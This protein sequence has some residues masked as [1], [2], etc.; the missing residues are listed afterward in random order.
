[1]P[2][3]SSNRRV[4]EAQVSGTRIVSG[5]LQVPVKETLLSGGQHA[6]SYLISLLFSFSRPLSLALLTAQSEHMCLE[7][8]TLLAVS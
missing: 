8:I 2:V 5:D 7:I 3:I 6:Y 1:M 4:A